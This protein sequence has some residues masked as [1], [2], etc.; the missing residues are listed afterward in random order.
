MLPSPRRSPPPALLLRC[1]PGPTRARQGGTGALL[2]LVAPRVGPWRAGSVAALPG[3]APAWTARPGAGRGAP[4]RPVG[5]SRVGDAWIVRW[6]CGPAR[7]ARAV[8]PPPPDPPAARVAAPAPQPARPPVVLER[9]PR[10]PVLQPEP[11]HPWESVA[12]FN[13]AA[14]AVGGRVHLLYRAVGPD[15][16]S[17]F[18]HA[19][20]ED[21]STF[22]RRGDRPVY[23]HGA[24]GA[25]R[26]PAAGGAASPYASGPSLYGCEDPRL[27]R[28]GDTLYMTYTV[29]D[30]WHAPAVALTSI[31]L[32]DFAAGR[33]AWAPPVRISPPQVAHKNWVVFPERIGGR[34]AVLHAVSP[35]VRIAYRDRLAFAPGEWIDSHYAASGH[36]AGWDNR[37]RGVG[38]PPLATPRGWLLLYHAMDRRDPGRYKLGAMLLDRAE[39]SRVLARLPHPL[40]APDAACEN[41][42]CKAGVVYACGAVLRQGWLHV[43]YGGADTVVCAARVRLE[44]L[45]DQLRPEAPGV[46]HVPHLP[47]APEAAQA[48]QAGQAGQAPDAPHAS[49]RGPWAPPAL[50]AV[51]RA[52]GPI[53]PAR[54]PGP[55]GP[56]ATTMAWPVGRRSQGRSLRSLRSL[57][58]RRS[59]RSRHTAH[60]PRPAHV[61]A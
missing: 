26:S 44:A 55:P 17:V 43:Y 6:E 8:P 50:V 52:G 15:G 5:I 11:A 34:F 49:R 35:Q 58:S 10:N 9:L 36:E 14:V 53:G 27:S 2:R 48:S 24:D 46:P 37:I 42:G 29:F 7:R 16:G 21:G 54:Q 23:A 57:R 19:V 13:P 3:T 1:R 31:A 12:V 61:R 22:I 32:A 28:V 45:L 60:P 18:G 30:G 47:D 59:H 41:E 33:W 25:A 39:P 4:G 38:P 51:R 40:L 20:S 56:D